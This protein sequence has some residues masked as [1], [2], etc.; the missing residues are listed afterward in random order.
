[1]IGSQRQQT[2]SARGVITSGVQPHGLLWAA[3]TSQLPQGAD[4]TAAAGR[5]SGQVL[6]AGIGQWLQK[7]QQAGG[8]C[9]TREMHADPFKLIQVPDSWS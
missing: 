9:H 3:P 8:V 6:D 4:A 7:G 1:M 2:A 5:A